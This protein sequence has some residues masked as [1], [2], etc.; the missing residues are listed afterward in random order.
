MRSMIVSSF[1]FF[2]G[3]SDHFLCLCELYDN[4]ESDLWNKV[5]APL[6]RPQIWLIPCCVTGQDILPVRYGSKLVLTRIL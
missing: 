5:L 2:H 3:A 4:V 6:V 1:P